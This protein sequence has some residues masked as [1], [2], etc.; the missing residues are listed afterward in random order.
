MFPVGSRI[1]FDDDVAI[2][3]LVYVDPGAEPGLVLVKR[4]HE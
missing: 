2:G 1:R 4:L 3:D